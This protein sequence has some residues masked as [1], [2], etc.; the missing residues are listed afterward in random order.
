MITK[1][2]PVCTCSCSMDLM[3]WQVH[4]GT[5]YNCFAK[6]LSRLVLTRCSSTELRMMYWRVALTSG[7]ASGTD[8]GRRHRTGRDRQLRCEVRN[9][10]MQV[11][12]QGTT[13]ARPPALFAET[14]DAETG[15]LAHSTPLSWP[16]HK[17]SK[18]LLPSWCAFQVLLFS[19]GRRGRTVTGQ[20]LQAP[21]SGRSV[22][23]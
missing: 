1:I 22:G 4:R 16:A 6:L 8:T 14:N 10:G 15:V 11:S 7:S 17:G 21:F 13:S 3:R 18:F 20:S 12:I 19:P 9:S 23:A 5:G 2:E